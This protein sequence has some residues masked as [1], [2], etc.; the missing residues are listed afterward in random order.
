MTWHLGDHMIS[1]DVTLRRSYD[2]KWHDTR[3]IIMSSNVTTIW[4][5]FILNNLIKLVSTRLWDKQAH[6]QLL[7]SQ[8]LTYQNGQN[9]VRNFHGIYWWVVNNQADDALQKRWSQ[10][11]TSLNKIHLIHHV[12]L[13]VGCHYGSAPEQ[14]N[15]WDKVHMGYIIPVKW[16]QRIPCGFV[17]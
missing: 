12:Q 17:Q 14:M 8:C 13:S 4:T 2:V 16:D 5:A 3:E 9:M 15:F 1:S 7:F 6:L 10:A 11:S